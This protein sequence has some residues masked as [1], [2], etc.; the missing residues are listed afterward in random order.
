MV[1]SYQCGIDGQRPRSTLGAAV[2]SVGGAEAIYDFLHLWPGSCRA[3]L[4]CDS[5]DDRGDQRAAGLKF[6]ERWDTGD[7]N[8]GVA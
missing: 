7:A 5:G 4:S 2:L 1:K 3:P 6:S 8:K